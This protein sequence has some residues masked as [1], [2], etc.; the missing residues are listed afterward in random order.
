MNDIEFIGDMNFDTAWLSDSD[1]AASLVTVEFEAEVSLSKI[2]V[3]FQS[4]PPRSLELQY[5]TT[6]DSWRALQ[7]YS[8]DCFEDFQEMSNR[9]LA[10][11]IKPLIFCSGIYL[12][13]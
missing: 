13:S 11:L 4:S 5:L 2:F 12:Y 10:T 1:E 9:K 8:V 6:D 7:Y 3:Y